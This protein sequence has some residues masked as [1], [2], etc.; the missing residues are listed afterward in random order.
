MRKIT[1]LFSFLFI[2]LVGVMAGSGTE[3]DPYS[4]AEIIAGGNNVAS[5]T[6][7]VGYIVGGR[8]DDFDYNSNEY[9][10][11]I[12]DSEDEDNVN[13]CVQVKL[14]TSQRPNWHPKNNPSILGSFVIVS[15]SGNGYGGYP[16]FENS[17]TIALSNPPVVA[18]VPVI[19]NALPID[20]TV[21]QINSIAKISAIVT[22]TDAEGIDSVKFAY[23]ETEDM[24]D[25]I[26]MIAAGVQD[27]FYISIPLDVAGALYGQVVAYGGND[28][29]AT[30]S[31]NRIIIVAP[32]TTT[33]P[34]EETFDTDFGQCFAFSVSGDNKE[35]LVSGGE[36]NMNGYNT[37][38]LEEDWLILPG[39]DFDA[40]KDENLTFTTSYQYG[41]DDVDNYLKLVYSTD[42]SGMG[43]PSTAN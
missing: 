2:V 19:S 13:N 33:L 37:G 23:G 10:I 43:D 27:S 12:A 14:S 40:Y 41:T 17:V 25:T 26:P 21:Y 15:G 38:D 6:Y 34:Y 31:K 32:E 22:T 18:G 29:V 9:A 8:Y 36:A 7:A 28:S 42:F 11:S 3:A 24:G 4:C 5:G 30:S 39:V 20:G 35:W 16:A 1:L